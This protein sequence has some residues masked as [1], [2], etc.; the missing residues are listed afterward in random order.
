MSTPDS[1]T[2]VARFFTGIRR[3][4]VKIGKIGNWRIFGGPYTGMQLAMGGAVLVVGFQTMS[5]WGPLVG[6]SPLARLAALAFAVAGATWS[7]GLIPSTR[8]KPH[9]VLADT[10]AAFWE[11]PSG[12][13]DGRPIRLP[14]PHT[15]VGRVL[16]GEDDLVDVAQR[17]ESAVSAAP[18]AVPAEAG[19][20][21]ISAEIRH[22]TGL[23][24][25][26]EQ[27]HGR[28]Y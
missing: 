7:A 17:E 18:P 6:S 13:V 23:D 10:A 3:V 24:R 12:L 15:Y 19:S 1:G 9:H 14:R 20:T 4:P 11:S 5:F 2:R 8:R 16:I 21:V 22:S 28:G 25:L 26:L 27:V